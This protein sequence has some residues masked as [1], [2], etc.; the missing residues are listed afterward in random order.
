MKK[1]RLTRLATLGVMAFVVLAVSGASAADSFTLTVVSQ[2]NNSITFSYPQQTGHGYFYFA[3]DVLVSR[4]YDST[5]TQIK[6]SKANT[7]K[8][9]TI[10]EGASGSYPVTPPP[11]PSFAC[12]DGVDNDGDGKIDYPSDPGCVSVTDT[13]ETDPAPPPPPS[14]I[15]SAE[16]AARA[17][18]AGAVI[19][20]VTVNGGCSIQAPSVTIQDSTLSDSVEFRPSANG[21]KLLRSNALGF[22]LFGADNVLIEDNHF[23]GR[24]IDNQN[25]IWDEPAGNVPERWVIRGNSFTR[26]YIDDGVTHSEALY[27]GYSADGLIETNTFVNNGNTAHV[28]FT[29]FGNQFNGSSYP[30]NICVRSNT[31]GATH[32]AFFDV[33]FHPNVSSVGPAVTN[34]RID[35]DNVMPHGVTN[36]EFIRD[37]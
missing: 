3:N 30:R 36:P 33:N 32:G 22:N 10:V 25:L 29:N 7:Y 17:S 4:T 19:A 20:N 18:I 14:T 37:C 31:F 34:I 11:P 27:V 6:F 35:P 9:A 12:S 8:V 26:Y 23:D 21:G 28:F 13:D 16:C 2:T 15:S 24:G 5:K 1:V